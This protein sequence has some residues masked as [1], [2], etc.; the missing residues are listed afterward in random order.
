MTTKIVVP[1]VVGG[2]I[3]PFDFFIGKPADG[4]QP[5]QF[6]AKWIGSAK[7]GSVPPH[8]IKALDDLQKISRETG[9][10]LEE[11]CDLA[12]N[13]KDDEKKGEDGEETKNE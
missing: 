9:V 2:Q 10:S 4:S 5:I 7:Q 12:F 13:Q 6:Q 8:I 3:S 11:L 1:C